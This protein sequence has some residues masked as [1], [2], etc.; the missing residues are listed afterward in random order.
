MPYI[1]R[2]HLYVVVCMKSI[3]MQT[4]V[5]CP[6][7]KQALSA[8]DSY[9]TLALWALLLIGPSGLDRDECSSFYFVIV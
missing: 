1:D 2:P 9:R 5:F 4:M 7:H 8:Y 6:I 3:S